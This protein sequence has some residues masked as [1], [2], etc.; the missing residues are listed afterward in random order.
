MIISALNFIWLFFHCCILKSSALNPP[1]YKATWIII[2]MKGKITYCVPVLLN[3]QYIL[4]WLLLSACGIIEFNIQEARGTETFGYGIS[5]VSWLNWKSKAYGFSHIS[6][7][8]FL[9]VI[10][11]LFCWIII[12]YVLTKIH[13]PYNSLTVVLFLSIARL[14]L[15]SLLYF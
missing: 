7:N 1:E 15:S 8:S 6:R 11:S 2:V 3:Y 13:W 4:I 14:T 10:H 9:T 12:R 5:L